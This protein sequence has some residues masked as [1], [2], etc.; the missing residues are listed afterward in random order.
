LWNATL[1][2]RATHVTMSS[3]SCP[4]NAARNAFDVPQ[5]HCCFAHL[6]ESPGPLLRTTRKCDDNTG[7]STRPSRCKTSARWEHAKPLITKAE[8]CNTKRPSSGKGPIL[9]HAHRM[10]ISE[11]TLHRV[12]STGGVSARIRRMPSGGCF[13]RTGSATHGAICRTA[14]AEIVTDLCT[15]RL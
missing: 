2:L 5:S 9:V 14:S 7:Q 15:L 4:A 8:R 11:D 13:S 3:M 10:S 12:P 6:D 1:L